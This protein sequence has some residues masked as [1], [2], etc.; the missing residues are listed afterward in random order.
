M[1]SLPIYEQPWA[2]W[3]GEVYVA[4]TPE[5]MKQMLYRTNDHP[6]P[7]HELDDWDAVRL[8]ERPWML[9]QWLDVGFAAFKPYEKC[10]VYVG[11]RIRTYDIEDIDIGGH[12]V[13]LKD[14]PDGEECFVVHLVNW[15]TINP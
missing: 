5:N 10:V 9:Y 3:L 1:E 15:L 7:E 2:E 13:P 6:E 4:I 11:D 8:T 14:V 12:R